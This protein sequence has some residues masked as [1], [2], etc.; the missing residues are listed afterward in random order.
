MRTSC[1]NAGKSLGMDQA[2]RRLA[3]DQVD[4]PLLWRLRHV[5]N[6]TLKRPA[7]RLTAGFSSFT[8]DLVSRDDL[9]TERD[10]GNH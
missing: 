5:E 9:R 1:R 7:L 10:C 3:E 8:A 6:F 2:G 4:R